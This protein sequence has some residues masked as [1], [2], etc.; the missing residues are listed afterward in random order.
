[1]C[2]RVVQPDLARWTAVEFYSQLSWV[3][4]LWSEEH[5]SCSAACRLKTMTVAP[6]HRTRPG[7]VKMA[8]Q[9]PSA[10]WRSRRYQTGMPNMVCK[11]SRPWPWRGRGVCWSHFSSSM[12]PVTVFCVAHPIPSS[13]SDRRWHHDPIAFGSFTLRMR[14]N[15]LLSLLW[16][17]MW[18]VHSQ[19][20]RCPGF[21]QP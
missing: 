21:P 6:S 19:H 15:L 14:F 5:V 10:L 18:Q 1:M 20:T 17:P 4:A 8:L 16:T 9:V 13:I 3:F 12:F 2:P 7:M 11:M